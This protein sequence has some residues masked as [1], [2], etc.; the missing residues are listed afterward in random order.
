MTLN[1]SKK[2]STPTC[3]KLSILLPNSDPQQNHNTTNIP[4]QFK[5]S[6]GKNMTFSPHISTVEPLPNSAEDAD[7][8]TGGL[9]CSI[10]SIPCSIPHHRHLPISNTYRHDCTNNGPV[11]NQIHQKYRWNQTWTFPVLS[12]GLINIKPL[13]SPK[14]SPVATGFAKSSPLQPRPIGKSSGHV[15]PSVF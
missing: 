4:F 5:N 13:S 15:V 3:L 14:V 8:S 9:S 1:K 12:K 7:H 6:I 2:K 11:C 10:C